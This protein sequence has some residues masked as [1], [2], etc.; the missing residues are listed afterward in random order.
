MG[1]HVEQNICDKAERSQNKKTIVM[2]CTH[3]YWSVLQVGSQHLARQFAKNGWDVHYISAPITPLHLAG[4]LNFKNELAKRFKSAFNKPLIHEGGNIHS[5]IPFSLLAPAGYPLLRD[6][7]VTHFWQQTMIPTLKS[8]KNHISSHGIDLLYI[9]N[10]S[11]HFLLDKFSYV[12]SIFR[13]MDI[14]EGFP[15]WKGKARK[16]AVKI[17]EKVDLTVYSAQ[18]L[19]NYVDSLNPRKS[20]FIPNGVDNELFTKTDRAQQSY[21]NREK[22]SKVLPQNLLN[23]AEDDNPLIL[24]HTHRHP[25]LQHIKNPIILYTGMIDSRLDIHLIR[26]AAQKLSGVTFVFSGIIEHSKL[27]KD[28]P[29]NIYFTGPVA[30]K[31]LPFLMK[32]AVAGI[33]PFDV[34]NRMSLIQGIRPLKLLEYMAAGLPVITAPWPELENMNSPAWIYNNEQ[35]FIDL[36]NKAVYTKKNNSKAKDYAAQNDWKHS[37]NLMLNAL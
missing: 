33:I 12:K 36:V 2:A 26:S 35:D 31:E 34:K 28:L 11:Y 1:Q 7:I 20:A 8:L 27:L 37:Y 10:L 3:P 14:H 24:K 9:D 25:L 32:D 23:S 16:L 18:S 30:H 19:K 15:G 6:R 5:Y 21:D 13:V 17:T 29:K 4:L 22:L